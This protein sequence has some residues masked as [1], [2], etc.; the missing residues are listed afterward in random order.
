[1]INI[2]V[3]DGSFS[4]VIGS[5]FFHPLDCFINIAYMETYSEYN[6]LVGRQTPPF[7]L[8]SQ[9]KLSQFV[10]TC[11]STKRDSLSQN[12]IEVCCFFI[13]TTK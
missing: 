2:F 8:S 6:S 9:D 3:A 13:Q 7:M 1:M 5:S 11:T 4:F 10:A 12:V